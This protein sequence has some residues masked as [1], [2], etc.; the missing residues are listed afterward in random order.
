MASVSAQGTSVRGYQEIAIFPNFYKRVILS[1]DDVALGD[2]SYR[3]AISVAA[4]FANPS[5]TDYT[6]Q[7]VKLWGNG[8]LIQSLPVLVPNFESVW[9]CTANWRES[10]LRWSF[11]ADDN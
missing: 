2:L 10:G 3:G 8:V 7:V 6:Y 4:W 11:F 1:L 9:H 5:A